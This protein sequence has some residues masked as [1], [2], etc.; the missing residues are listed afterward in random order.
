[1]INWYF[2]VFKNFNYCINDY[3]TFYS[4]WLSNLNSIHSF[5]T[6]WTSIKIEKEIRV[7]LFKLA[8]MIGRWTDTEYFTCRIFF[9]KSFLVSN[10]LAVSLFIS[11]IS[12]FIL[13]HVIL[14]YMID[15]NQCP[16]LE[17]YHLHR[18]VQKMWMNYI[19][20]LTLYLYQWN[21][22]VPLFHKGYILLLWTL[23]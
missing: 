20:N 10:I 6:K 17:R 9:Y 11:T 3:I 1:M 14:D 7:R 21:K 4:F 22:R 8:Q 12:T 19:S 15:Q 5:G 2:L 13:N 18:D 16:G 23:K